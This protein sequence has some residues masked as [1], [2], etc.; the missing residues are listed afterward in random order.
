MK[1]EKLD[2]YNYD[3]TK[4]LANLLKWAEDR[5]L[6]EYNVEVELILQIT[7][8]GILNILEERGEE[9]ILMSLD[10]NKHELYEGDLMS[11]VESGYDAEIREEL[12]NRICEEIIPNKTTD[13]LKNMVDRRFN[14]DVVGGAK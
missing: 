5:M 4:N 2:E 3:N 14:Y 9:Y 10:L 6:S 7:S 11:E 8:D 1:C 13:Q 12:L